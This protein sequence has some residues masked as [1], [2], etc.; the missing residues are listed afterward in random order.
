MNTLY[1]YIPYYI[2]QEGVCLCSEV[3]GTEVLSQ[4]MPLEKR[5][6]KLLEDMQCAYKYVHV[7]V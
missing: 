4:A 6:R 5:L 7:H 3:G 1:T 2:N